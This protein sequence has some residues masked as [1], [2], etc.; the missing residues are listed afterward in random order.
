MQ[1]ASYFRTEGPKIGAQERLTQRVAKDAES[2]TRW[3]EKIYPENSVDQATAEFL[4]KDG[5]LW[6][7]TYL[8]WPHLTIYA[9]ISGP[10]AEVRNPSN[11]AI[12]ALRTI[13][14]TVH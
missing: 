1:L 2:W 5:V 11:W 6:L 9:T 10:E 12:D 14:L 8:V 4:N 7:H 3:N 13:T